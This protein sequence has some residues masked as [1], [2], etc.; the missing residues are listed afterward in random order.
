MKESSIFNALRSTSF[1]ILCCVL[2]RSIKIRNL[3][4]HGNKEQDGSHLLKFTEPLTESMESR[5]NSS[6]TSSQDLMRC[7]SA[8]KSKSL[9]GKLGETPEN[10]TG[11]ILFMSMFNDISCG[12]KD[13]EILSGKRQTRISVREKIWKK[14]NGNWVILACMC[15]KLQMRLY[16]CQAPCPFWVHFRSIL[17]PFWVHFGS[18]FGSILGPF[19]VHFGSILG[20]FWVHF[21]SILGPFWVHF[22][23]ILGPFWV[24]FAYCLSGDASF[25]Q[26]ENKNR[27]LDK[28]QYLH[29]NQLQDKNQCLDKNVL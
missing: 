2:E 24:H 5:R 6:G 18:I 10:F 28:N 23:S 25:N 12:T 14:D 29:Q 9:L 27:Y 7:S 20:P 26:H 22:G 1:E 3:T 15:V 8:T 17:G 13:N 11:R 16:V 19:W 4:K 21:G